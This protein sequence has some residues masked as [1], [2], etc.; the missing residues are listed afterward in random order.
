M[1]TLEELRN[2]LVKHLMNATTKK[3]FFETIAGFVECAWRR[4]EAIDKYMTKRKE[5]RK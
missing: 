5:R 2:H 3:E 4:D 1:A